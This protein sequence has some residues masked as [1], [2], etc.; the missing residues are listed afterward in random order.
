MKKSFF[1]TQVSPLNVKSP[2]MV[3]KCTAHAVKV[4]PVKNAS[5]VHMAIMANQPRRAISV[6]HAS[7]QAILIQKKKVLAIPSL[8][9]V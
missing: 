7:V 2:K 9:T 8:V 4:I 5:L 3:T 1:F 6:N